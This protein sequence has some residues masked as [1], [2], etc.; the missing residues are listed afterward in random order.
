MKSY[1]YHDWLSLEL[2]R[3]AVRLLEAEPSFVGKAR[4]TLERWLENAD[5]RTRPLLDAWL[6]ILAAQDWQ[7]ALQETERG[8]QLRSSSPL[9]TILP[10]PV[11]EAILQRFRRS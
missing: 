9:S 7:Q 11:R 6:P 1:T 8:Q 2:H 3:E 4:S 5:P 10:G